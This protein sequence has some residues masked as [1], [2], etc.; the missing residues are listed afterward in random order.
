MITTIT[1]YDGKFEING[2]TITGNADDGY[3]VYYGDNEYDTDFS[4]Y[5]FEECVVWCMNS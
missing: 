4:S 5:D 3:D 2:Y 1:L